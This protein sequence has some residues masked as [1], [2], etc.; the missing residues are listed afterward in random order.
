MK[1]Y[2]EKCLKLANEKYNE[3]QPC[4]KDYC[5]G[6]AGAIEDILNAYNKAK[7]TQLINKI[8]NAKKATGQ[9]V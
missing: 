5:L 2:L 8:K 6:Y 7:T 1:E 9:E 4:D 3:S